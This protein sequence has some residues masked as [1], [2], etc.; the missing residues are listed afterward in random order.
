MD[1]LIT[2]AL[3]YN[4]PFILVHSL[5]VAFSTPFKRH[6]ECTHHPGSKRW[7]CINHQRRCGHGSGSE[8]I[9]KSV[10]RLSI[11]LRHKMTHL[12]A[13]SLRLDPEPEG[14]IQY[15][16][17]HSSVFD[18][19][20]VRNILE[21]IPPTCHSLEIDSGGASVSCVCNELRER[22]PQL[23]HLHISVP[24]LC[25]WLLLPSRGSSAAA[26]D[27]QNTPSQPLSI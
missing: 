8:E 14:N 24:H 3:V 9:E 22:M 12:R 27:L 6:C 4:H 11:L 21:R 15:C 5:T 23:Y 16:G 17:C 20:F 10:D 26:R 18:H 19:S 2:S 13:F 25:S 7:E 1:R